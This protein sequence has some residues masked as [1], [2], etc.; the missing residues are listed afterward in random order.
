[1]S[2]SRKIRRVR[3]CKKAKLELPTVQNKSWYPGLIHIGSKKGHKWAVR[4]VMTPQGESVYDLRTKDGW[5]RFLYLLRDEATSRYSEAYNAA[6]DQP[7]SRPIFFVDNGIPVCFKSK[8]K[9]KVLRNSPAHVIWG[10]IFMERK[11]PDEFL[12][13]VMR[14]EA[15]VADLMLKGKKMGRSNP[16]FRKFLKREKEEMEKAGMTEKWQEWIKRD[17]PKGYEKFMKQYG[18]E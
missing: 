5:G 8:F 16:E 1:M 15:K 13:F 2:S 3:E 12:F 17:Y 4:R 14:H 10:V 11:I 6:C 7:D 9:S 18:F